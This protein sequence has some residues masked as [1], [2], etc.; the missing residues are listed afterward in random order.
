MWVVGEIPGPKMAGAQ[1]FKV[2]VEVS[3]LVEG[4]VLEKD[5]TR[6]MQPTSGR[7]RK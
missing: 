6:K 2:S 4:V 3:I 5:L 1:D 7:T